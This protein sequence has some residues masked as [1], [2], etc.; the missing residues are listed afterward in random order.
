MF[1]PLDEGTYRIAGRGK[2]RRKRVTY[3]V[4][5][6]RLV[7]VFLL[8]GLPYLAAAVQILPQPVTGNATSEASAPELSDLQKRAASG[9]PGAQ[10]ALGKAYESGNGVSKR[11]DLAAV[12]YR[13]SAEQGNEKAQN[14]LG[15]LYWSGDGI[16]KDKAEAVRWYRKSARQ[17]NSNA[18]FNL[19]AAYY[20]GEGVGVDDTLAFSWFLLSS[21]AG[22]PSGNDAAKRSQGES[23]PSRFGDACNAIGRMYEKGDELPKNVQLAASWYRKAAE[24]GDGDALIN[25]AALYFGAG[26]Y[27]QA[28]PWCEAAIKQ[29]RPGGYYCLGYFYQHGYGVGP[30]PKK[31]MRLYEQAARAGNVTSMQA[32]AQMY[33]SGEGGKLDRVQAFVWFL[34]AASRGNQ[35]AFTEAKKIRSSMSEKEWKNTKTKLPMHLDPAKVENFLQG[36]GPSPVPVSR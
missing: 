33:E 25:L 1:E 35:S 15:A 36:S 22:N 18:M 31:A 6:G 5:F 28:H 7:A 21:E 10:Y 8:A 24:Q 34:S 13:K 20:N 2:C 4:M 27:A 16:E 14:A 29:N 12:W 11:A 26:D 19:G 9:D 30:N 3:A 32:L 17:G 23:G